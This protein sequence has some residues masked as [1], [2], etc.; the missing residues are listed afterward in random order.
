MAGTGARLARRTL[1]HGHGSPRYPT[2]NGLPSVA[3]SEWIYGVGVGSNRSTWSA[4]ESAMTSKLWSVVRT[5]SAGSHSSANDTSPSLE[6]HG[7]P[8]RFDSS[9]AARSAACPNLR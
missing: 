4:K 5:T 7:L 8:F 2:G 1:N 3:E 6:K 9:S